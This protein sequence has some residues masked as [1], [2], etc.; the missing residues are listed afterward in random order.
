MKLPGLT[1]PGQIQLQAAQYTCAAFSFLWP[2]VWYPLCM[3]ESLPAPHLGPTTFAETR[4]T[5]HA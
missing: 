1:R 5:F 3:I 4:S 2:T